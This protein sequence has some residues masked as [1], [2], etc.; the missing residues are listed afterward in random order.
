MEDVKEI[1][2]RLE[3]V[4][5]S[6]E[7][8]TV[9]VNRLAALMDGD[10]DYRIVGF[11]EQL[12]AYIKANEEWKRSTEKRIESAENNTIKNDHRIKSLETDKK[13][14]IDYRT[15]ALIITFGT[16]CLI[17]AYFVLTWMQG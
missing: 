16:V 15:A 17:L 3:R 6:Q 8:T 4:E 14:V 12:T 7:K 10:K 9:V 13:I 11:P 2:T 1:I 5:R